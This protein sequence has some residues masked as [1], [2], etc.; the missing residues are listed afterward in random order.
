MNPAKVRETMDALGKLGIH[1]R[2]VILL[3]DIRDQSIVNDQLSLAKSVVA[4]GKDLVFLMGSTLK[5]IMQTSRVKPEEVSHV[6][7]FST[8]SRNNMRKSM[9]DLKSLFPK[10]KGIVLSEQLKARLPEIGYQVI[11]GL[12][13][14]KPPVRRSTPFK[15]PVA[16]SGGLGGASP[17]N[18][19][20]F[21][22]PV[23]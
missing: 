12:A 23:D 21:I 19:E 5:D 15:E 6:I 22:D 10:T 1:S 3:G 16:E 4:I 11:G 17:P 8:L 9:N 2:V 13:P 20:R 7:F 18:D 14:P